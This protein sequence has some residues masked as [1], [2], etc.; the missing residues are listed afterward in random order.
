MYE[1]LEERR[2]LNSHAEDQR[3]GQHG[4]PRKRA[5]GKGQGE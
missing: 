4:V 5:K 1:I 2:D 3:L